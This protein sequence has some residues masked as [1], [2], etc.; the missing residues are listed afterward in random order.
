MQKR[1]GKADIFSPSE[2]TEAPKSQDQQDRMVKVRATF[3][4]PLNL[5]ERLKDIVYFSHGLTLTDLAAEAF[6][7][8]IKKKEAERGEIPRRNGKNIK[9]GRPV[10]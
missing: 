5:L 4:V 2:A 3:H 9:S 1:T 6:T 8:I 10:K 7:D